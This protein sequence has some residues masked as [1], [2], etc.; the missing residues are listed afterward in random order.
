MPGSIVSIFMPW[1][2]NGVLFGVYD[3]LVPIMLYCAWSTLVF[4][5]LAKAPADDRQ[6]VLRWSAAVLLLPVVGAATYL[7]WGKSDLRRAIR[8]G[9]VAGG[10]AVVAAAFGL[11]M[12]R[13]SY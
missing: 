3:Y 12:A 9:A 10:L 13:I 1:R 6:R 7:L 11:T 8:I 4:L 2:I 5:D